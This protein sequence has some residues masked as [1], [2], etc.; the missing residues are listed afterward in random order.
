MRAS[1]SQARSLGSWEVLLWDLGS[2]DDPLTLSLLLYFYVLTSFSFF[3]LR[4][5][6]NTTVPPLVHS[7][8]IFS[9]TPCAFV[10]R[11]PLLWFP[12]SRLQILPLPQR[13]IVD[14]LAKLSIF[15]G[16]LSTLPYAERLKEIGLNHLVTASL[17]RSWSR[18]SFP[19]R[20]RCQLTRLLGSWDHIEL[21]HP[22]EIYNWLLLWTKP[23]DPASLFGWFDVAADSRN[24]T[25]L[26]HGFWTQIWRPRACHRHRST[27]DIGHGRLQHPY[28]HPVQLGT[29]RHIADRRYIIRRL[30]HRA[31][32]SVLLHGR[33]KPKRLV[34]QPPRE[35][36]QLHR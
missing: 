17:A 18:S 34:R 10:S 22:D 3:I 32:Q 15:A 5:R 33:R 28:P 6:T 8:S 30:R 1:C 24:L 14:P 31:L 9:P 25:S 7:R 35:P 19:R 23:L 20:S 2:G 36:L 27:L 4:Y 26:Q 13:V 29:F 16:L 21:N 11:L 12:P